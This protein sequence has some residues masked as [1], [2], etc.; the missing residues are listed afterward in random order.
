[1]ILSKLLKLCYNKFSMFS[2]IFDELLPV[3]DLEYCRDTA[4]GDREIVS[5]LTVP[6]KVHSLVLYNHSK[7]MCLI[8][9]WLIVGPCL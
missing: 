7:I 6:F 3:L 8:G 5:V 4:A 2:Y 1:M 9:M